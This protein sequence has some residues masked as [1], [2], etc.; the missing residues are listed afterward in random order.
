MNKDNFGDASSDDWLW[1][2]SQ[3]FVFYC[4]ECVMSQEI[5]KNEEAMYL[6]MIKQPTELEGLWQGRQETESSPAFSETLLTLLEETR[7]HSGITFG[8]F[9]S[10]NF[11]LSVTHEM[12][13]M[14]PAWLPEKEYRATKMY[15]ITTGHSPSR[16]QLS[17]QSME[18]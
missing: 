18:N 16:Q 3:G 12:E 6:Q 15:N 17:F 13:T 14:H 10:D 1:K 2:C 7:K 11:H 4:S 5:L 9:Q 8:C